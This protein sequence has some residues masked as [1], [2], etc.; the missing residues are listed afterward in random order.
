MSVDDY[1]QLDMVHR[2]PSASLVDRFAYLTRPR[3]RTARGARRLRRRRLPDANEQADAWLHEHL[4][5]SARELVGLD[6][7]EEGVERPRRGY[8]AHTVDCR[9]ADAV[10]ALGLAPADLVVAGEVIE[11]LDDCGPFLDGL[12]ALV[13]PGGLLAV[14]TPNGAG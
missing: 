3:H 12:H 6:L 10:R 4:A 2:L 14:T 8:D 1:S 5:S 7:D 13:G 9:D 11:H